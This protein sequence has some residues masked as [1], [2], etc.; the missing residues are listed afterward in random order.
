MLWL[1]LWSQGCGCGSDVGTIEVCGE[2]K[3]NNPG[4]YLLILRLDR[5]WGGPFLTFEV[6]VIFTSTHGIT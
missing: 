6:S 2:E 5:A 4:V 3:D 1:L